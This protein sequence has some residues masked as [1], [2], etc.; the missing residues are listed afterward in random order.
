[1]FSR[2]SC[3]CALVVL[4]C[5]SMSASG[6]IIRTARHA[7][8]SNNT[9]ATTTSGQRSILMTV[10]PLNVAAFQL[11]VTFEADKVDFAGIKGLNG[12][13]VDFFQFSVDGN[14]GGILN[15][16]GYY[17]GFND[18][19]TT[20]PTASPPA[21]TQAATTLPPPAGEVDIFQLTFLDN[22]PQLA[23]TFTVFAGDN[24]DYITAYNTD[25]G[26]LTSA[27]G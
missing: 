5:G 2:A 3:A 9:V 25:T 12:Y 6:A 4:C 13:I 24:S 23:K 17:P 11:D 1:M 20:Q 21:E 19:P 7:S 27:M 10:D 16:H 22:A 15:I 8:T 26:A 18:R 14:F